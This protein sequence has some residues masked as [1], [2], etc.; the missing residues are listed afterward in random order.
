M[1]QTCSL[2]GHSCHN[3]CGN[4][5]RN[6]CNRGS[7]MSEEDLTFEAAERLGRKNAD[8]PSKKVLAI[9][10]PYGGGGKGP[11]LFSEHVA[12]VLDVGGVLYNAVYTTHQGHATEMV[13]DLPSDNLPD[14]IVVVGGDGMVAE[15]IT[16]MMS[17]PADDPVRN[18]PIS[19]APGGTANAFSNLLYPGGNKTRECLGAR[20][21]LALVQG[22][23]RSVDVIEILQPE[24]DPKYALSL[25]GWGMCGTVAAR[26]EGMRWMPWNRYYRYDLAGFVSLIRDWPGSGHGKAEYRFTSQRAVEENDR[27]V[28]E[29]VDAP[30]FCFSPKVHQFKHK[31]KLFLKELDPDTVPESPKA[32]RSVWVEHDVDTINLM[33]VNVPTLGLAHPICRDLRLNDGLMSVN[34]ISMPT[35]RSKAIPKMAAMKH[36][37][38]FGEQP[39]VET[40]KVTEFKLEPDFDTPPAQPQYNIDG[41]PYP[42]TSPLHVKCLNR[43]VRVYVSRSAPLK[44]NTASY[45]GPRSSVRGRSRRRM[46]SKKATDARSGSQRRR[47]SEQHDADAVP[48]AL[49]IEGLFERTSSN[50]ASAAGSAAGSTAGSVP[51]QS[52]QGS[53]IGMPRITEEEH[54]DA[55]VTLDESPRSRPSITFADSPQDMVAEARAAQR[56]Q[57]RQEPVGVQL[58]KKGSARW[59]AEV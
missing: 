28:E 4:C 6:C 44:K 33:A 57:R 40:F 52:R 59:T 16:G 19:I 24:K 27:R 25:V 23:V 58:A 7:R 10:N 51:S 21:A 47:K 3:A 14:G 18:I 29:S 35:T 30:C 42:C 2:L 20:A 45:M 31:Q 1:G 17:R 9:I 55:V 39:G 22:Y 48:S 53:L 38:Y 11:Q 46:R 36:G 12:P 15:V 8:L 26:A 37:K 41:D 56:E 32:E 50:A 49:T 54:D 13:R 43:G 34:I 5:T